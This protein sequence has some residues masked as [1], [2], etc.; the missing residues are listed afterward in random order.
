MTRRS[1]DGALL[2]VAATAALLGMTER[3]V[4]AR[5]ARHV[6]PFRKLG[7]KIVFVRSELE[8]F[9]AMLPGVTLDEAQANLVLRNGEAVTR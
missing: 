7:G 3:A 5:V 4:R 2:D 8:T 1:Y 6:L 9:I